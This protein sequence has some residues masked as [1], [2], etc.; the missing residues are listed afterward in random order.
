MTCDVILV[1]IQ[2]ELRFAMIFTGVDIKN[3]HFSSQ[4]A[5]RRIEMDSKKQNAAEAA[6]AAMSLAQA[7]IRN[8]LDLHSADSAIFIMKLAEE[9]SARHAEIVESSVELAISALQ[10]FNR[11]QKE[12]R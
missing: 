11:R 12:G 6:A 2:A 1:W 10:E 5:I 8:Y 4:K 9:T 7:N 3:F